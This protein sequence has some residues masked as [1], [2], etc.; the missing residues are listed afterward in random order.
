MSVNPSSGSAL[1][2]RG[3]TRSMIA[4]T[5]RHAIPH[6][7]AEGRLV[8]PLREVG[9][10]LLELV[11]EPALVLG[12]RDQL[13]GHAAPRT[14]SRGESRN[15]ATRAGTQGRGGASDGRR[16]CRALPEP[17]RSSPNIAARGSSELRPRR[18]PRQGTSPLG[19]VSSSIRES[20]RVGFVARMG[21]AVAFRGLNNRK[22]PRPSCAPY[23]ASPPD[24]DHA[25]TRPSRCKTPPHA[26][27]RFH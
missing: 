11:R 22:V 23:A 12:P 4:P 20:S 6:Q 21:G 9:D 24:S 14:A 26:L 1:R 15:A 2:C 7:A 17:G 25:Q 3:T 19:S 8:R 10:L 16:T 27:T 5:V 13:H 18:A